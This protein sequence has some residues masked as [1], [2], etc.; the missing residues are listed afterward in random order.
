[1]I[2]EEWMPKSFLIGF[3]YHIIIVV[4]DIFMMDV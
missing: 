2:A 1:M 3:V 4:F